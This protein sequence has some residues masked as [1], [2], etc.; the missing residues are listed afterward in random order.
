MPVHS[1]S[2]SVKC[3]SALFSFVIAGQLQPPVQGR[4]NPAGATYG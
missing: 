3:L 1:N 4:T 2:P